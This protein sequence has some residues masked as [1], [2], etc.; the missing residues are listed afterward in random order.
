MWLEKIANWCILN[1]DEESWRS[2]E[3]A[4]NGSS[5]VDGYWGGLFTVGQ[6]E[7]DNMNAVKEF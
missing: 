3:Q 2:V 7:L 1:V 5:T 4:E 6:G